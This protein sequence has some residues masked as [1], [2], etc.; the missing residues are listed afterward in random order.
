MR[1]SLY[2]PGGT[3]SETPPPPPL[4]ASSKAHCST[5]FCCAPESLRALRDQLG[6]SPSSTALNLLESTLLNFLLLLCAQSLRALHAHF[7]AIF[8]S[9]HF[10]L[11]HGDS[12]NGKLEHSEWRQL[13]SRMYSLDRHLAE[14]HRHLMSRG[15]QPLGLCA[16]VNKPSAVRKACSAGHLSTVE[17]RDWSTSTWSAVSNLTAHPEPGT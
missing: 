3:S 12:M 8:Q 14:T 11:A 1:P 2:V 5:A 13:L 7:L 17:G 9:M 10:H 6:H 4:H 16:R 15:R